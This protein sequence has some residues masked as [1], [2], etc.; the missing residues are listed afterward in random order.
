MRALM[1]R[2]RSL[3]LSSMAA[4]KS[5]VSATPCSFHSS[6]TA[7]LSTHGNIASVTDADKYDYVIVGAGSAGCVLANRLSKD[8]KVLVIEAGGKDTYPWIHVPLGYLYTMMHPK[9]SWRFSTT[10]QPGLNGKP[11]WYPRGRVLGGCSSIN[12]MIYQ[13]GQRKDYDTWQELLGGDEWGWRDMRSYFDSMLDYE[14][15]DVERSTEPE[16]KGDGL[17]PREVED[18]TDWENCKGGEW[19]VEKQRLSWELLDDFCKASNEMGLPA[20]AHFNSSDEEGCGYFQVNQRS[21]FRLSAYGAFIKPI[22][23]SR[24]SNL[25][26]LTDGHVERLHFQGNREDKHLVADGVVLRDAAAPGGLRTIHATKEVILSAGAI[27]SPHIL[28]CSGIGPRG[29]LERNGVQ[30]RLDLPGVGS[31]LHDH[32]QIRSAYRLKEGTLTLN[33]WKKAGSLLGKAAIGI[34][35]ALFRSGPLSMAPSQFGLFAKSSE[36]LSGGTPDL[37]FHI[38]PLSLDNLSDPESMHSFPGL[39]TSVCNLRPSSRGEV[40]LSGPSTM[41]APLINPNYLDTEHDKKVAAASL[42]LARR[43]VLESPTFSAKYSPV[44]HFPGMHIESDEDLAREAGNISTSIFHPVGTCQMAREDNPMGVVDA[45]LKVRGVKGL[46]VADASI[47]PTIVS[48]NTN[49][50]TLAI[51]EKAA[52][53]IL[54]E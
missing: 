43:L 30:T 20:R 45:A 21:G 16:P 40:S 39:T 11:L 42:R 38:Q 28:Q 6:S 54:S 44:E 34:E 10:D 41:D 47:M 53:M 26:I 32:L 4:A 3:P 27:G 19:H 36:E 12:G 50:P 18:R 37:Q 5:S 17:Q 2:C 31:N 46:R 22:V 9:T 29:L 25:H 24:K 1:S 13:R 23:E 33:S 35:Y 52:E 15:S 48:G 51:A 14:A 49:S 8:N 7:S